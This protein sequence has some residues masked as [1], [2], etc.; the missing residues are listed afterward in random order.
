MCPWCY[1]DNTEY[2]RLM[3]LKE[4]GQRYHPL[5]FEIKTHFLVSRGWYLCS[6]S[7]SSISLSYSVLSL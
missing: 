6:C 2:E 1:K 3:E 7:L 5:V 4:Q